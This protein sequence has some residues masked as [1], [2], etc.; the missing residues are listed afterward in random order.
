MIHKSEHCCYLSNRSP[1]GMYSRGGDGKLNAIYWLTS[2]GTVKRLKSCKMLII[3]ALL[4][5]RI[6]LGCKRN[7]MPLRDIGQ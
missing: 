4:V 2:S 1:K 5:S 7:R 3:Y 6:T